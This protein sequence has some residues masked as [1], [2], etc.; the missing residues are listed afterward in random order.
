M[1]RRLVFGRTNRVV[2][3]A[4]IGIVT[5]L[6][7]LISAR[8]VLSH[9]VQTSLYDSSRKELRNPNDSAHNDASDPQRARNTVNKP[10]TYKRLTCRSSTWGPEW[11]VDS[12]GGVCKH[13]ELGPDGCCKTGSS[14]PIQRSQPELI[15]GQT[16]TRRNPLSID[17]DANLNP[18][19][20]GPTNLEIAHGSPPIASSL[21]PDATQTKLQVGPPTLQPT[22]SSEHQC[23]SQY[24]FC[25]STCLEFTWDRFHSN[26]IKAQLFSKDSP[27]ADAL[28]SIQRLVGEHQV[29]DASV[30]D[31]YTAEMDLFDWCLLRCRTSG[32]SVVHQN[33]FRSAFKYCYGTKDP[34]LLARVV[35]HSRN[36]EKTLPPIPVA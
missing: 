30:T 26:V 9:P 25:V 1:I 36:N 27:E 6:G 20:S 4:S 14:I 5:V 23:C 24:E 17:G 15:L 10:L 29:N 7:L 32:R 2:L 33:A 8:I 12:N 16:D 11:T 31:E 21:Q 13:G 35:E 34:P 28:N 3:L 19:A 18:I 22:C